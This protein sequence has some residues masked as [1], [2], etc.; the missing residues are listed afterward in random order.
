MAG[1]SGDI[2]TKQVLT[3]KH[4]QCCVKIQG[5]KSNNKYLIARTDK[6]PGLGYPS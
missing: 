4:E 5:G 3:E 6:E 2:F 1:E